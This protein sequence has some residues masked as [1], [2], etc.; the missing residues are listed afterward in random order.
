MPRIVP[1][2]L[3]IALLASGA[4]SSA[5]DEV[6]KIPVIDTHIHLY[7]T[8]RPEGVPWPPESDKVLYRPVLPKDFDAIAKQNGITATVIVEASEWI[9]DNK[10]VLDLV[11][12]DPKKY[13]GLVGSLEVGTP[14]FAKHLKELSKD[15]RYVGIRL[16]E[17][18]RGEQFFNDDVWRDLKLLSDM[19]QTLDVLMFNFSL[20]DVAMIAER[21]P[22]LKILINHVA[23]S[24]VDGKPV[25]PDWQKGVKKA[26]AHPNVYCKISGLFQQSHRSPSPT[27]VAFYKPTLDV[28]TNEFGEDRLVYGSN[29]PVTMRGG[30]YGDFKKVVI[31]YYRPR[32]I[33]CLEKLLY[34]NA[35]KFYGLDDLI[36]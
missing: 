21:L 17:R 10:W 34:K 5:A 36:D 7:D 31:D 35:L 2:S 32:G 23:G 20:D 29:W 26:A 22:K 15:K 9:P 4:S 27:D 25:D 12:H 8:G 3:A 18:P 13:K 6:D 28:L 11:A 16:R 24:N 30:S 33:T 1:I 19:D 14:D